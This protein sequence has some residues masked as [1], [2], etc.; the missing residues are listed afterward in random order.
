MIFKN[1]FVVLTITKIRI[2][3]VADATNFPFEKFSPVIALF[4]ILFEIL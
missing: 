3:P 1:M 2:T 4:D